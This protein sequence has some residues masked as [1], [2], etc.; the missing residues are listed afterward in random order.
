VDANRGKQERIMSQTK[1]SPPDAA[2]RR[3]LIV[4]FAVLGAFAVVM[5]AVSAVIPTVEM[6]WQRWLFAAGPVALLLVW[7]WEFFHVIRAQDEM[8]QTI[9]LRTVAIAA[10]LVLLGASL[11]GI[12]ERLLDAPELPASMLLPIFALVYGAAWSLTGGRQ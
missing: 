11:W 5:L 8:M 7:A 1:L 6:A 12:P 3:F 9:H 2:M 10:G 4:Q